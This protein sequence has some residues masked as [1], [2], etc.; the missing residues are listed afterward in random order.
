[1]SANMPPRQRFIISK[2]VHAGHRSYSI[3]EH[4]D[5]KGL[6]VQGSGLGLKI[7]GAQ[8]LYHSI[9]TKNN[10]TSSHFLCRIRRIPETWVIVQ[11]T[12]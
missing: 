7:L 3:L 1:M 12:R 2:Q 10:Y 11:R 5:M 8:P 4:L 6:G 9:I